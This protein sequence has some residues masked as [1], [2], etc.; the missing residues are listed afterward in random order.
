MKRTKVLR[1]VCAMAAVLLAVVSATLVHAQGVTTGSIVGVVSDEQ[2]AVVPGVSVVATHVPSGTLYESVTQADGRFV[3]PSGGVGG[4]YKVS[5][6][7]PGFRTEVKTNV[8]VSLGVAAD[9]G[10]KLKVAAISEEVTVIATTDPIFSTSH[11]GA[12]T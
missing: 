9:L 12:A 10:F 5:V 3:I 7:L 1:F 11:T 4:P 6:T 2:G 8:E